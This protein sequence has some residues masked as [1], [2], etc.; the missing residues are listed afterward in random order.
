M[1]SSGKIRAL[2]I[3]NAPNNKTDNKNAGINTV[4]TLQKQK[5][6]DMLR[7]KAGNVNHNPAFS[8][9]PKNMPAENNKAIK[10]TGLFIGYRYTPLIY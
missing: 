5:A 2:F 7:N 10:A 8:K 1:W 9:S 3:E 6:P 4:L